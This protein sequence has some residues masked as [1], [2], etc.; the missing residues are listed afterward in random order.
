MRRRSIESGMEIYRRIVEENRISPPM[1]LPSLVFSGP[2][3]HDHTAPMRL[4]RGLAFFGSRAI[5][6]LERQQ[7]GRGKRDGRER[8]STGKTRVSGC[9]AEAE[10]PQSLVLSDPPE[11]PP[12]TGSSPIRSTGVPA[13]GPASA[14]EMAH[15]FLLLLG[16][17]SPLYLPPHVTAAAAAVGN[18]HQKDL[19]GIQPHI[20]LLTI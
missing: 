8:E 14:G 4:P 7:P 2:G 19:S 9:L 6:S 3:P 10:R 15:G 18:C 1:A 13:S 16:S 17:S 20:S 12:A 5:G 11:P